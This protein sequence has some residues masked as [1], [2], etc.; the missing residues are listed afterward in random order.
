[1]YLL[2]HN[3]TNM[4]KL[5]LLSGVKLDDTKDIYGRN[6]IHYC[7]TNNVNKSILDI[8]CHC[9]EFKRFGDLCTYVN[10]CLPITK[11]SNDDMYSSTEKNETH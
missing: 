10:K 9:I 8:I 1:M 11:R 6:L 7:C 3:N 5:S 4:I 2:I